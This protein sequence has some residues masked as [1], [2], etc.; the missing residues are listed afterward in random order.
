MR[1][2]LVLG[3]FISLLI[4]IPGVVLISSA[5]TSTGTAIRS[6]AVIPYA[7]TSNNTSRPWWDVAWND[8]TGVLSTAGSD[9]THWL[10]LGLTGTYNA[11]TSNIGNFFGGFVLN[12]VETVLEDALGAMLSLI[13]LA[14]AEISNLFDTFI[15]D[16]EAIAIVPA[17]GAF[18][19]IIALVMILAIGVSAIVIVR[20]VLDVA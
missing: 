5:P 8:V 16:L 7:T 13:E 18:G 11:I 4:V 15:L 1:H 2:L 10:S 3:I 6:M 9:A 20:L 12:A 19:P 17:L 14:A